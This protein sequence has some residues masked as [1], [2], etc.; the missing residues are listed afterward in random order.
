MRNLKRVV[1]FMLTL[2]M[3]L[4]LFV[5]PA[6]AASPA[7]TTNGPDTAYE[8]HHN[9]SITATA[10]DLTSNN[11][12][13]DC[14]FLLED[15]TAGRY[16]TY[17]VQTTG[18][19]GTV[20]WTGLSAGSYRVTQVGQPEVYTTNTQQKLVT[21]RDDGSVSTQAV[22]FENV[23]KG[24]IIIHRIDP[25]NGD[26]V[27]GGTYEV[28]NAQGQ[29]VW[30]GTANS[31]GCV[32]VDQTLPT[33]NYTIREKTPPTGYNQVCP[34]Q[35]WYLTPGHAPTIVT[36]TGAE[37]DTITV[38]L[39]DRSNY[40]PISGASFQV[41]KSEGSTPV[42]SGNTDANGLWTT[43]G[44]DPGTYIVRQ[45][46]VI[47]GYQKILASD[48]VVITNDYEHKNHL[49]T[50]Y[51][52]PLGSVTVMAYDTTTGE[53][54]PGATVRLYDDNNKLI[55]ETTSGT[56]GRAFFPNIPDG[57]YT[58]TITPPPGYAMN[59]ASATV[60]VTGGNDAFVNVTG[61]ELGSIQVRCLDARDG[62][63]VEG[64][65][66]KVYRMNGAYIGDMTT[67]AN[68][69][70]I[71]TNLK[72]GSYTVEQTFVPAGYVKI[73][74]T[75]TAQVVAGRIAEV[76][77]VNRVKPFVVVE[78]MVE[79]TR[80]PI[81]GSTVT[82]V[83][84]EGAEVCRGYTDVNGAVTFEDLEPGRYTA[85]YAWAP[86]GYTVVVAT[87]EVVVT[88][89][90]SG[91]ACLTASK[92]S[93]ILIQKLDSQTQ[94]PLMGATFEVRDM[95][96]RP[97]DTVTTDKSGTAS[98]I[99]LAPGNYT[100]REY[101]APEHYVPNT[102]IRTVRVENNDSA[103]EIFTN[104]KKSAIVVYAYDKLGYAMANVPYIVYD[105]SS[106]QEVAH[107]MT[108]N[109]GFATTEELT[110][111]NYV[112]VETTIPDNY[113]L[114]NPI[115]SHIVLK[116]GEA[117]EVRYVHVLKSTI[118]I[119]TVDSKNGGPIIGAEY[120]IT[121]HDSD[122]TCN[123]KTDKNGEAITELLEEGIYDV[124]QIVA[125][126]GYLLNTTTQTVQVLRDQVNLAKFFNDPMARITIESVVQGSNFGLKECSFTIEN[127]KGVEVFHA[128]T[129]DTGMITTHALEPDTYTV[130]EIAVCDGYEIV[131]SNR[132]VKIGTY[133]NV[134]VKFEHTA[135]N[136]I[137]VK[138]TNV[139]N[140]GEGLAGAKFMVRSM[141][142]DYEI[143]ITTDQS[144]RAETPV[145][146]AGVYVVHQ[147][148]APDGYLLEQ[149][150]QYANVTEN[151]CAMVEFT[152]RVISGLVIEAMGE[153]DHTP[154]A[155]AEFEIFHE[156][157]KL[158]EHVTT[159]KSGVA[160]V[161]D[162]TPDVYVVKYMNNVKEWTVRQASQKITIT[163]NEPSTVRFFYT[164]K[165]SLVITLTD[166]MSKDP[167]A[168]GVFRVSKENGDIVQN[169]VSTDSDGRIV[170]PILPAG[171]YVVTQ[172]KA[173]VGYDIFRT[174]VTVDV[175][176]GQTAYANITNMRHTGLTIEV[177]DDENNHLSGAQFELRNSDGLL[178]GNYTAE[179]SGIIQISD[180][181]AG[182][183]T[184]KELKVPDGWTAR[185]LTQT[186]TI[187]TNGNAD[188]KFYHSHKSTM[189]ID[190][191]DATDKTELA[192][193]RFRITDEAGKV[194]FDNETTDEA[195]LIS[196]ASMTAGKYVVTQVAAPEGYTMS[197]TAQTVEVKDNETCYVHFVNNKNRGVTIEVFN[198]D[199]SEYLTGAT[200][201]VTDKDG[202]H[203]GTYTVDSTG[204]VFVGDLPAG[205]YQ[206]KETS[207]PEGWTIRTVAQ[208]ITIPTTNNSTIKF[209]HDH[210]STLVVTLK[211]AKTAALLV[212]GTFKVSSEDGT[213]VADNL[214]T[215]SDGQFTIPSM[216]AG[217]YVITQVGA[218]VGY[219][220]SKTTVSVDIKD[221][222][223]AYATVLNDKNTGLTVEVLD[224]NGN[225]IGGAT[226]DVKNSSSVVVATF[227]VG[228]EGT[229]YVENLPA[230]DYTVNETKVPEG[231]TAHTLTQK[232]TITANGDANV[233]FLHGHKSSL[234]VTLRDAKSSALLAN[235]TFSIMNANG[236]TVY[237]NL[238]TGAD[239]QFTINSVVAGE[240][241]IVQ[242]AAPD[243]YTMAK[244]PT[245]VVV[246]DNET[247][248]ATVL[249]DKNTGLTVE[250][251]DDEGNHI[252]GASFEVKNSSGVVVSTFTVGTEG[253]W[254][255][256]D[257][258]AGEYTVNETK[259]PDGWTARTLSQ[260][261]T[262][263]TNGDAVVKFLH[264]H[265]SSLIVTLRDA[266]SKEVLSGGVFQVT[267][268]NGEVL[269]DNQTTNEAG[270]FTI[271]S[272][273]AG[274]YVITQ[275]TAP[276][277]YTKANTP[278]K[279]T[280][281][282]NQTANAEVL[283][284]KNTGLT[285]EVLDDSNNRL[286]GAEFEVKNSAGLTVETFVVDISGEYH[287]NNLPA[288]E[289]TVNELKVP[290]GWTARTLTQKV[291]I[292]SAGDAVL[293]FFHSH[294][295]TLTIYLKDADTKEVLPGGEFKV[296][297][298]DGTVIVDSVTTDSA[299]RIVLNTLTAGRYTVMQINAPAGYT[300]ETTPSIVEMKDN[301]DAE[302]TILNYKNMGLIIEVLDDAN[303][304]LS[305]GRFE[306][307]NAENNVIVGTYDIDATGT[308]YIE[309]LAAGKYIIREIQAPAGWTPRTV[310]QDI[311]IKNSTDLT[312]KFY[313]TH[314][315]TLE[316]T[317]KDALDKHV[318]AG[319]MFT[320]AK[321]NGDVVENV[322]TT[323]VSG[324]IILASVEAGKYILT[325][326]TA[327]E[328]YVIKTV[329]YNITV[330]D[331]QTNYFEVLNYKMTGLVIETLDSE[332]N[333]ISGATFE[334]YDS[335][336]VLVGTYNVDQTGVL[337]LNEL[338]PG[339]YTV[340]E[341]KTP[342]GWTAVTLRQTVRV[343]SNNDARLKFMHTKQATLTVNLKDAVS[344]EYLAGATYRITLANG[345]YFGEYKT[346]ASG[347]FIVEMM[348]AG[349][350]IVTMTVA[351][352]GYVI[353]NTP[354]YVT[355]K[356]N[357]TVV[358]D[359]TLKAVPNFRLI[360]TVKQTGAPI[361]GNKF[362]I[363]TYDGKPVGES[364]GEYTTDEAGL[365][366]LEL[367]PGTYT[368]YQTFVI[369][370]C[371]KNEEVWNVVIKAGENFVLEVKN[372][373]SSRLVIKFV[374]DASYAPIYNVKVEVKDENNNYIGQYTTDNTGSITLTSVFK[375]GKYKVNI[376]DCP[377]NYI[378]DTVPKTIEIKTGETTEMTWK[379]KAIQGA[380]T[381]VTFAGEDSA[382]MQIAKNSTLAGA[383]YQITDQTGSVVTTITGDFNGE[384]HSGPLPIGTYYVQM[385][386]P[387]TGFQLNNGR[388]TVNV[389]NTSINKRVEVFCKAAYYNMSVKVNGQQTVWAGNMLKYTFTNI[390]NDSSAGMNNFYLRVK[391]P[392]DS[393]RAVS[394]NTGSFNYSTY[395]NVEY[396]TNTNDWRSL[397][398]GCSSKSNYSYDLST[399]GL[400]LGLG[401]YVTDVRMVF[402]SVISGFKV[403]TAPSIY[404]A[405]LTGLPSGYMATV[406]A[407]VGGQVAAVQSAGA[408][409]NPGNMETGSWCSGAGQ[410][411]TYI[412]NY[413][414]YIPGTLPKTG[415]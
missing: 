233:K 257:L 414:N 399:Q 73:T 169:D 26:P 140:S 152:N 172:I 148:I 131:Q 102:E 184:I 64:A 409:S 127:S 410:Y 370:G 360:N 23:R 357:K 247:A 270:Q 404:C 24:R 101:F 281:K 179:A 76:T 223:T 331:D 171:R 124:K 18:E 204:T 74:Q 327:P 324:K 14:E 176:D 383:V 77:F 58:T 337:T 344:G 259:V 117:T 323:D 326:T 88:T 80:M 226:F 238:T 341:L 155:G 234:V 382:M 119:Q 91:Y 390:V 287:I 381:I 39:L 279:V 188:V 317:L 312:V 217:R 219:T 415:Y 15:L 241:T 199:G 284:D 397:A 224:D 178:I 225:H 116:A 352:D 345:E 356:D 61:T 2:V 67:D 216:N 388:A 173:P 143:E 36:F 387:P 209:Y 293:K 118:Q 304:Y 283:N 313:H 175:K 108:N 280:V 6:A 98:T 384:A 260:K 348:P 229:W 123:V 328:G 154:I 391:I 71:M 35:S 113:T 228:A 374:D 386:T 368:V 12:I 299:G 274:N 263:T 33:G 267:S 89:E 49:V 85:K 366:N 25:T 111:G 195:G 230:G 232:V 139:N 183:Y 309:N 400:G 249:N 45:T 298:E 40:A 244:T 174:P 5:T 402:P 137:I 355:I 396:K 303:N 186:V 286:S 103:K 100:I 343:T 338:A 305:G 218:P 268:E 57:H 253:T 376:L 385:V 240:Y 401:E 329:S 349:E 97:V 194:L 272:L 334:V 353:D 354:N 290:D 322:L 121:R 92:H 406:R 248:T 149:N 190:L 22:T 46:A 70:A 375:A 84:N 307:V 265:K 236:E 193:G 251:L 55:A 222:Q 308:R 60:D 408:T 314:K 264:G 202:K 9:G 411:T 325:Q 93:A 153:D 44:L 311:E 319:G 389:I 330:K 170:L 167:L 107:I 78:T 282:D 21:L 294:Q 132:T 300:K 75:Q 320:L 125:P 212:G 10:K 38:Q 159:D 333:H 215:G 255:V 96:G 50:L 203:V 82:L 245:K 292:T 72:S 310:T 51:N 315:S 372:E 363:M 150:Y 99:I 365:I 371:V 351:P 405:V 239:G 254:F 41:L 54:L 53:P 198:A 269:F 321:E 243:G 210:K 192:N 16:K 316:I 145:L 83:S 147:T 47:D 271:N 136:S 214:T 413:Q 146:P 151:A 112:V 164:N 87:Q 79:G 86:D 394:F 104:T 189:V 291:T 231:W 181:T 20:T 4:S 160:T 358:L 122:Y 59:D 242:L 302:I 90:V 156:N 250:A 52:I 403:A 276:D 306:L 369:D 182:Q 129:D 296:V 30:T 380:I 196:I 246:K 256:E 213:V 208:T 66:Y 3:V 138:L 34:A 273:D 28:V 42:D 68:G 13:S 275:L 220:M 395:Y 168:N 162:L 133:E 37:Y 43:K 258:T 191:K 206:I 185:T 235:G 161:N 301:K 56:D 227:T 252:S 115:Q 201:D 130:K 412:Y 29:V 166:E 361:G 165:S 342:E 347:Q 144:G 180:L 106:G 289:Y 277:G 346:N 378:K 200:F 377:T 339:E 81:S 379:L 95:N 65:T 367:K 237:D 114:V 109:S 392:T 8:G 120:L 177:L 197:T 128:T 126:E 7:D 158:V 205:E 288:G 332:N 207:G 211:D 359:L 221:N 134:S 398:Q 142:G 62:R 163:Q 362:K 407:E 11:R 373:I 340:V 48:T 110:P 1:S 285:V 335:E 27:G 32:E 141:K 262:V 278:T 364:T 105:A 157:G 393:M 295:S 187:V 135:M 261:V 350:Y 69:T 63:P 336:N 17:P 297:A 19:D 94:E 31:D 266:K 318:L